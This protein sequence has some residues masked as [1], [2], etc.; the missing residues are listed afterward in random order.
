MIK[1]ILIA[2]RGE[3]ACRII[4]TAKAMGIATVAVYS[5]PDSAALHVEL[6]DEAYCIGPAAATLSYLNQQEILRVAKSAGVEAVHPGY[7][8]LSENPEFAEACIAGG[9]I[10]VG[11]SPEVITSLGIKSRARD[12][13]DQAGIPVIPGCYLDII[14]HNDLEAKAESIGY[15]LLV[16]ADRGGGGKGIRL[17]GSAADLAGAIAA[18]RREA[19]GAF[20][21]ASLLMEKQVVEA[22][23]VE[24]QI[25]RDSHGNAV[26]LFER[27]CSLQ[28]R[29]QKI[30][31]ESP[32]PGISERIRHKLHRTAVAAAEAIGY[33]GAGT[34]EFLVEPDGE[35]Y[36]LEINTR[37]QV[38]HPVTEMITGQDLVAWQLLVAAGEQLP[39]RQEELKCQ[40]HAIEVRI[41]AEDPCRNFLPST[42]GILYLRQP[43]AADGIRIDSGVRQGDRVTPWYDPMLAKLIVWARDRHT[44]IS[45]L[46]TAL[47]G[48]QV[49]GITVNVDFLRRLA[50]D[51]AF[52]AANHT[53]SYVDGHLDELTRP[54]PLTD[55]LLAIAALYRVLDNQRM[56][57][58]KAGSGADPY[59]PWNSGQ[60]FR[61]NTSDRI[62]T[63]F[64]NH[65]EMATVHVYPAGEGYRLEVA[66]AVMTALGVELHAAELRCRLG[67]RNVVATLVTQDEQVTVFWAGGTFQLLL[68]D[69]DRSG[70]DSGVG[71][72]LRAPIPGK[73]TELFVA[74]GDSVR[75]GDQLLVL[76]AMKME[77]VIRA[78]ADGMVVTLLFQ[79]GDSVQEKDRLVEFQPLEDKQDAAA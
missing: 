26:H 58:Q 56:L 8:F 3:I 13:M 2:N 42:G 43:M 59:S 79:K 7:G 46:I 61:L 36:F 52:G 18:A 47:A 11:P 4:R 24:V 19:T 68:P 14:P 55:E 37:L 67:G 1:K 32:A 21:D 65:G 76:E 28:R 44:A 39:L 31:E 72:S 23:H 16:K 25:F 50:V 48:Y 63:T 33:V 73:V 45:R 27:D 57:Y 35:F 77:Y 60:G 30:L 10:F 9:L 17:V 54:E 34:V 64:S 29:H 75:Q 71:N 22:R 62:E 38:E 12:I 40:G 78:P 66:G 74:A 5:E 49:A 69:L 15:P 41:Y 6:A 20:G 51:P 70:R 53:T